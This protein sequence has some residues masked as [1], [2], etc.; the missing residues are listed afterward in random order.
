MELLPDCKVLGELPEAAKWR[1]QLNHDIIPELQAEFERQISPQLRF[2]CVH[3]IDLLFEAGCT[4]D[5][6]MKVLSSCIPA[7]RHWVAAMSIMGKMDQVCRSLKALHVWLVRV[8][9]ATRTFIH[10]LNSRMPRRLLT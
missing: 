1:F 6:V 7:L 8:D 4:D 5:E 3:W 10:M 9:A 2:M